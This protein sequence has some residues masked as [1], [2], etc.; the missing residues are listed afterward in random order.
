MSEETLDKACWEHPNRIGQ[1]KS[2]HSVLLCSILSI[3]SQCTVN[4]TLFLES[5]ILITKDAVTLVFLLP[6][7]RKWLLLKTWQRIQ[8]LMDIYIFCIWWIWSAITLLTQLLNYFGYCYDFLKNNSF[9]IQT[10]NSKVC[11][12]EILQL[13]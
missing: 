7:S 10:R 5:S 11:V 8:S 9:Y 4:I 2:L 6:S 12:E 13:P 1:Y 3:C